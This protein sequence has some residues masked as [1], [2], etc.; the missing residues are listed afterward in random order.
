MSSHLNPVEFIGMIQP[1]EQSEIHPARGPSVDPGYLVASAQ[2][3]DEA[4]FDRILIGWHSNGPD[5]F[6]LAAHAGAHT[7][8]VGFLVAHRPGFRS[9]SVA[10]RDYATLDQ[11]TGGRAAIHVI[12][13]GDDVDQ[14]RDGD[15]LDKDA[16]YARTDEYVQILKSIWTAQQPVDFEGAYYRIKGASPE[17][18]TVQRPRLPIYFGGASE[19][20]LRV[21]GKHADV[22]ALWGETQAQVREIVT[23]VRAE[24]AKHGRQNEVRFSL[25]FRPILAETEEAAWA[26]AERILGRIRE[27]RGS[28]ILGGNTHAPQNAGSQRLLAAAALG[29]R[30]EGRLYTA[31]ARETGARGNTTALV[32]TPQQV[33]EAFLEYHALGVTTFLI[34][35]F[36]PLED[37]IDYGRAL[38]PITKRLV[39]ERAALRVAAE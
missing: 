19:A 14:A 39:A 24:A 7:K 6:Q 9:P 38:L 31:I 21:A 34:R 35:G 33:A 17:V 23:R 36:D 5:G 30:P 8:K 26:K 3:H 10:A 18:R 11:L 15:W 29:D 13:G 28:A 4:G 1:R 20:A 25:S 37:A 16:R 12:S 27:I 32:G 2:A 22:Y